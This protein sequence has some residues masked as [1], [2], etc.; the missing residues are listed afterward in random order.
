MSTFMKS[1]KLRTLR[2]IAACAALVVASAAHADGP[3][4]SNGIIIDPTLN[5][6]QNVVNA[7][8]VNSI[9]TFMS[10]GTSICDSN[11]QNCKSS[12]GSDD[13]MNYTTMQS[14]AQSISGVQAEGFTNGSTGQDSNQISMQTGTLALA[15]GDKKVHNIA[16]VAVVMDSCE[17]NPNGD[18]Q[19]VMQVCTAPSRG[20]PVNEPTNAVQCSTDPTAA[21]FTPPTGKI[22]Y[23]PACDTEPEGSLDGWSQ[24]ATM[25]FQANMPSTASDTDQTNNGLA[26]VFYPPVT[27]QAVSFT[28][29]SENMTALKIPATFVNNQTGKTAVGI[30]VAYRYQATVTASMLQSSTAVVN[31]AQHTDGWQTLKMLQGSALL[32]QYGKT[33]EANGTDCLNQINNGLSTDGK[34][35]VCDQTYSNEAGVHPL[36]KEAQVAASGQNCGTTPQCLQSVVNTNTWTQTCEA[37]V[38]L[39]MQSC[40][41]TTSYTTNTLT[42]TATRQQE[43]CHESRTTAQYGCT[44]S[45]AGVTN[46]CS[47]GQTCVQ[48]ETCTPGQTYSVSLSGG[49]SFGGDDCDGGDYVTAQWVCPT[50]PTAMPVITMQTD[51]GSNNG[52]GPPVVSVQVPNNGAVVASIGNQGTACFGQFNNSTNCTAG[53][54][55]GVYTLTLGVMACPVAQNCTTTQTGTNSKTGD[56]TY[57]TTCTCPTAEVFQAQSFGAGTTLSVPGSFSVSQ[58]VGITVNDQCAS[59]E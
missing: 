36:A 17:V 45:G 53:Q 33:Y 47:A 28:T 38:P 58:P 22:C 18:A 40:E 57:T 25:I 24:P 29:Q 49:N 7:Q 46:G 13:S 51:G 37:N 20:N 4:S 6:N 8:A 42:Y 35:Y 16:G 59:Y 23:R 1:G 54:C 55:S 50:D 44:T 30:N 14:Q 34:I 19:V 27:G 52:S 12:F 5:A 39:A 21:N 26:L 56:P 32:A 2:V 48:V 11:G 3:P 9:T 43:V 15:C 31:P 41:T 10:K